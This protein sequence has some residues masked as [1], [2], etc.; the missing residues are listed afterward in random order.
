MVVPRFFCYLLILLLCIS[1][2][3]TVYAQ[4]GDE[5]SCEKSNQFSCP[6]ACGGS[7]SDCMQC[8]GYLNTGKNNCVV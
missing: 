1:N 4:E 2:K 8:D 6:S 5:G 3:A 7:V